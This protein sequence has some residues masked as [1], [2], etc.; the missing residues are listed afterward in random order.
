[1]EIDASPG[2]D[3]RFSVFRPF[4]FAVGLTGGCHWWGKPSRYSL[5]KCATAMLK[6][7][8]FVRFRP[9]RVFSFA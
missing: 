7:A 9:P 5:L 6:R 8:D 1:M 4:L 2:F 3:K